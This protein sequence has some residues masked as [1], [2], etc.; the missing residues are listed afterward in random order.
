M[1]TMD[2]VVKKTKVSVDELQLRDVVKVYDG[3]EGYHTATVI[4]I[5]DEE[6]TLFRPY[7]H[8]T[9]FESTAG[10]IPYM[11][12]EQYTLPMTFS[13]AITLCSRPNDQSPLR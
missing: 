13:S 3:N 8:T 12:F 2:A 1:H 6:V 11:G 10:V 5:T 9:D 7:V 4:R